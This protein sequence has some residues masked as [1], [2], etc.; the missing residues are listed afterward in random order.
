MAVLPPEEAP[1]VPLRYRHDGWT[2]GAQR[3]FLQA[4]GDTGCVR[5]ACRAAGRSSTSAYRLRARSAEFAASWDRALE[6]AATVLEQVAFARAVI[7]VEEP[8]W[9][10]GKLVGTRRRYSD[11]LLRLLIQRGDLRAGHTM[12]ADEKIAAAKEMA[13][14]AG[15]LFTTRARSEEVDA[16]LRHKLDMVAKRLAQGG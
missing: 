14:A 13:R 15:G 10:Y 3:H 2:A 8:V 5:D 16:S 4:L 7:G 6:M 11:A 1:A 12:S 9:H